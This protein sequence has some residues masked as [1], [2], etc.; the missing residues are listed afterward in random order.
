MSRR[1]TLL[2]CTASNN[3]RQHTDIM[4]S[5]S[6]SELIGT[7]MSK[8]FSKI[9]LVG[10]FGDPGAADTLRAVRDHLHWHKLS[11]LLKIF[12]SAV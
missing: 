3:M 1:L 11:V 12:P 8:I 10:K 5:L 2:R 9:G 4:L 6:H 7:E